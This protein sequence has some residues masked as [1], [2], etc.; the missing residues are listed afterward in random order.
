MPPPPTQ[1]QLMLKGGMSL[2]VN[3][4]SFSLQ[5]PPLMRGI[6]HLSM[7]LKLT[8]VLKFAISR[9]SVKKYNAGRG[10]S[11]ICMSHVFF[12]FVCFLA[13]EKKKKLSCSSL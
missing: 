3:L 11:K 10:K 5:T 2:P 8:I 12:L 4:L 9:I 7:C 1:P 13:V 6:Y